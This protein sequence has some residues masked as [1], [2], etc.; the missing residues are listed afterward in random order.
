MRQRS[1]TEGL[2]G[3]SSLGGLDLKA[4]WELSAPDIWGQWES[5]CWPSFRPQGWIVLCPHWKQVSSGVS[6]WKPQEP[7]WKE[8]MAQISHHIYQ[9]QIPHCKENPKLPQVISPSGNTEGGFFML[10]GQLCILLSVFVT[11]DPEA[12]HFFL[13][14]LEFAEFISGGEWTWALYQCLP[15]TFLLPGSLPVPAQ[16]EDLKKDWQIDCAI[17]FFFSECWG[18]SQ[19]SVKWRRWIGGPGRDFM[20]PGAAVPGSLTHSQPMNVRSK[21]KGTRVSLQEPGF[22]SPPPPHQILLPSLI[23]CFQ[24]FSWSP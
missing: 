12:H 9:P 22:H 17:V 7:G 20:C 13:K 3:K 21:E 18:W 5:S 4:K 23:F 1:C 11:V 15:F 6:A 10:L 8:A 14:S 2:G 24:L 19:Q 16:C